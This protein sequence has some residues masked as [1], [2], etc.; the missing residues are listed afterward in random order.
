MLQKKKNFI[1]SD[2]H[3]IR[4]YSQHFIGMSFVLIYLKH[5]LPTGFPDKNTIALA[6]A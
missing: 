1:D 6:A 2:Y 5:P 3:N 4:I